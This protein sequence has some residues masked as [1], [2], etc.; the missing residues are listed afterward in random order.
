MT[1]RILLLGAYAASLAFA[2]RSTEGGAEAV[3]GTSVAAF[4][5]NL[6][7]LKQFDPEKPAEFGNGL[8]Q[9]FIK[10]A[11]FDEELQSAIQTGE[12]VKKYIGFEMAKA[13]MSA[14]E[15]GKDI[16]VYAIFDGKGAT[17]KLNSKLLQY[18][19]VI[20]KEIVDEEMVT[21]WT[22]PSVAELYDYGSIDKEKNEAEWNKR[23]M[24]RKRL[25]MRLSDAAKTAAAL[26]DAG[27]KSD[28]L[29]LIENADTKVIEPVIENAPAFLRGDANKNGTTVKFGGRSPNEGAKVAA[30]ISALVK[31]ATEAHA[32]SDDDKP[33][34]ETRADK[35]GDRAGDAKLGI[36]DEDF[37]AIVNNLRRVIAAQEGK[38][39][40]E[41]V[42]QLTNLVLY[43]DEQIKVTLAAVSE[44]DED[45]DE[46]ETTEEVVEE[47]A[48]TK[49]SKK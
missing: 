15:K 16:N 42:K 12:E 44:K 41:Q 25:N 28:Q 18:F 39:S 19:G 35:G 49:T 48:S 6:P 22:D 33:K 46:D 34:D 26:M 14:T 7:T 45:E 31:A 29:K 37:G 10:Q 9:S 11:A 4:S 30:N 3:G 5:A 36:S 43:I 27:T 38:L 17:E 20:K 23:F 13:V 47:K 24:N 1:K 2:L 40:E 8:L 32:K 21:T